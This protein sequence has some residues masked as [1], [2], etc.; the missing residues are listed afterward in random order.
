MTMLFQ[1]LALFQTV[2]Y[3]IGNR[4]QF[5]KNIFLCVIDV[6]IKANILL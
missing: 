3:I 6:V 1:T 4:F 5:F 2:N